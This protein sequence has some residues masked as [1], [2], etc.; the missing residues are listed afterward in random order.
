MTQ[1]HES[2]I[3]ASGATLGSDV[4]IG[5]FCIVGEHVNLGDGVE[6]KS[7]VVVEGH[8]TVGAGTHIYPFASIGHP[9]QDLKFQGEI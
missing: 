1:I 9:P 5:P 6:L 3:V 8:T 2:A 7:H 4:K